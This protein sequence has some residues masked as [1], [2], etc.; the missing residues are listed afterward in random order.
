MPDGFKIA[1][2]INLGLTYTDCLRLN[3]ANPSDTEYIERPDDTPKYL[4]LIDCGGTEAQLSDCSYLEGGTSNTGRWCNWS[5]YN[6]GMWKYQ[7]AK[8]RC[9]GIVYL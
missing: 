5:T 6:S 4:R 3:T 2:L 8:V 7:L 1:C 9:K